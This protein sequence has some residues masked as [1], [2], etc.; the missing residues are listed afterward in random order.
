ML[1]Q[2]ESYLTINDIP[3]QELFL[4]AWEIV[5]SHE[6]KSIINVS[7]KWYILVLFQEFVQGKRSLESF[8]NNGIEWLDPSLL[9]VAW[10]DAPVYLMQTMQ[11]DDMYASHSI[12]VGEQHVFTPYSDLALFKAMLEERESVL[13]LL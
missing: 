2:L 8:I 13:V 7:R 6:E 9:Q 4:Q 11:L 10:R 12:V 5:I 1:E 3:D